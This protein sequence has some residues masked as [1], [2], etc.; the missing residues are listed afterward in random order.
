MLSEA[1][2]A[3]VTARLRSRRADTAGRIARRPEDMVN[4]PASF[5]QEQ[6]WFLDRF[7]PGLAAYNIPLTL[8]LS[9]PLD[10]AA[11]GRAVDGLVAR[12][13]TLRTRLVTGADRRPVQV[14][15]P[16]R[17][18][19]LEVADLS[20]VTP[21]KRQ[22]RLDE[23][24]GAES[25]RP[26]SLA[27]EPLLRT[28]LVRLAAGEHVLLVVVHHTVFDG[29][30]ARVLMGDLAALYQAEMTGEPASLAELPVQ[31]ADFAVWERQRMQGSVLAELEGYWRGVLDG[32]ETVRFPADRP[33]PAVDSFEGGLADRMTGRG[34]L[35]SLRE[36]S[37]REGTTLFVTLLAG[38]MA[39][40]H[41]Y[42]SQD[43]LVVGTVSANRGRAVLS[44]LIGFLVNTL[45]IRADVSGDPAFS[46][47]L[48]R[49]K[50]A[51]VG[52][53]AHQDL[54]FGQLVQAL[55]VEREAGRSPVFQIALSY[56]E[57]DST[58]VR[59]AGV[60]FL[61]DPIAGIKAAKFDLSFATEARPDGLWIE[62]SYKS[63]LFDAATVQRLLGNF[64]VLLRGVAADPS[65]R[66]SG[67]PLLTADELQRE[68]AE[69]NDT[70][71]E[72]PRI[73]AHQGFEAQAARAPDAV[74]AQFGSERLS[75]GELDRQANRIARRLRGLGVGSEVLVGVCMGAGPRRLAGLLGI[76]KA[77]GGYVP[78]DPALPA[79][80]LSFMMADTAMT[81]VLVDDSTRA[82]LPETGAAALAAG[83]PGSGRLP[84]TVLSLDAEWEQ[85]SGLDGSD[86]GAT[87][88]TPANVAYVIYTSG[89]T[90]QPKGVVVE[91]RQVVNFLYGMAQ[92]CDMRASD[93]ML[94]FA[95]LS[96]DASLHDMFM[97]LLA[98]A[99]V[100]LAPA[101]TLHSPPRLA[102]LIRDT[103]VTF[104]CLPP[105][106]LSLLTSEHFPDLRMLT[107]G[108]EE[109]SSELA[110]R[111]VRP[112]LRFVNDYG[113]TEATV[114]AT[115]A[116]LGPDTPLPPPIGGP[117][118]NCRAYVLDAYLN[119]VP[120]GVTG[121]LHLGGAGVARG[122]LGRDELTRERFIPDPFTPRGRLY[123]TG[124][125]VRRRGDGSLVFAGRI[126]GQ[127]KI[128]GLRVELGEIETALA[129]H[130]AI[131]QAV[132]TVIA[133]QAGDQELA[134]YL[135][136]EPGPEP[137]PGPGSGPGPEPGAG[138]G[139]AL[140]LPELQTH[141][142]RT[143]PAYMIPR[144]LISVASF[145]LNTSGKIDRTALP[146][147]EPAPAA[148][149][150]VAPATLIETVLAGLYATVL[151]RPEVSATDSFFDLGGS[152]LQ[153]MR[154]VSRIYDETGVDLGVATIFLHPTPRR[155]A[156]SIDAI[157]GG[158][159]AGAGSGPLVELGDGPGELPMFAIHA[160]GGTV[161][162]YAPLARELGG[163]FKVYGLEAPGLTAAGSTAASLAGLVTDYTE[164]IRA[165]RPAG[166]YR[167][168][169]WSMGGV[170]A[171][172]I[173]RRL[174]QDG[175]EVMLLTLLD[176]PFALP[177]TRMPAREQLAAQFL[178]DA[179]HSLGWDA[180]ALPDPAA[181]TVAEQLGW[182]ARRLDP[183]GNAGREAIIARLG[184]RF[185]VFQAHIEMMTGYQPADPAVRAPTLIV[186]ADSSPNAPTRTLWPRVLAG[187]VSTLLV[188]SDHYAFLHP[189]LIAAVGTSILKWHGETG[190]AQ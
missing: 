58:P 7:A 134:A 184:R 74:A 179:A 151:G 142:A 55:G 80:R 63:G 188:D 146:D 126:D 136:P 13:E 102:A 90:G 110:G 32:F 82:R 91:H 104:V 52:A 49:V 22:A 164:R 59:A 88:V 144:H 137:S 57:Q 25:L 150:H 100:V 186:S 95:P 108:G 76:W 180:A 125:L 65:A 120:A 178:A 140:D 112:G 173:A 130:P 169:G 37:H 78:L 66:L 86:L 168:A 99:R 73:C 105:A 11:L 157:R 185:A 20:A 9:G 26:F 154:L 28:W 24:I 170:V 64:E 161:F 1:Q 85:I 40:L 167:L 3:A 92:R 44:P 94:Q 122:Y 124:D 113:P 4:L 115:C 18:S 141:L 34:L 53:Y 114:T 16:P 50:Q 15:D 60:E 97:P 47:L 69:W 101:E 35:D 116:E 19:A 131:A 84:V 165:A 135:R 145:P 127:V 71:A 111:W 162:A 48:A 29:W 68:L 8:R 190:Q 75:Y 156:A 181:A 159:P 107:S 33:R 70:A 153:A 138:T 123:K 77:G 72:F 171:F 160:V 61:A 98:G 2:R 41:R 87:A 147:P 132:V 30:S 109:L 10:G 174:E 152:S 117:L 155:L 36:L 39:L 163:T 79:D 158:T 14:V 118:P 183:D 128:R 67:L 5:G 187:P 31:F 176:A 149:G 45:P 139:L 189:P 182:L 21:E 172:E 27:D 166:P 148:T 81:A 17:P 121:E 83:Q 129:A 177:D 51:T 119:P 38:L 12:H 43:D 46:E 89:S 175:A 56:A 106:V 23:L 143:L 96:F 42:T 103:R 133:D 6:L 93:A 62:C 54:P